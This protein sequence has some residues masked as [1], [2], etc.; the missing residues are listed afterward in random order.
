LVRIVTPGYLQALGIRLREGRDFNWQDSPTSEP[1]ILI[2]E[3]AAHR[4][5][6]GQSPIGRLAQGIG[7]GD[8]K[9]VGVFSDVRQNSME[10]GTIPEVFVPITQGYPE[11]AELVVRSKL[12]PASIASSVMSTLRELNPSQP[13]VELRPIRELVDHAVSPRRFFVM[14]VSI[15]AA[16]GLVLAALGIYGVISYSVTRQTQEIGIRMALGANS[17]R[18]LLGVLSKTVRLA[19]MGIA[20]GATASFAAARCIASLL[21]RTE[22]GDPATFVAMILLLTAVACAAGFFPARRAS[23]IDPM[24]ALRND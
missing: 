9:V 10:E 21:F 16:L 24:I 11:G 18:V 2:N 8:T 5:W 19:M 13:R 12:P 4:H 1:V 17:A 23:S 20:L 6:P 7:Y 15:F 22:P 3:T 14:L